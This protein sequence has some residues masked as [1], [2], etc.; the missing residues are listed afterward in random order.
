MAQITGMRRASILLKVDCNWAR[1][2]MMAARPSGVRSLGA[3]SGSAKVSSAMPAQKCLPVLLMTRARD[4]PLC[5]SVSS[6]RSSSCQN[7]GF[8]VLKASGRLSTRWAI[9]STRSRRKLLRPAVSKVSSEIWGM[10]AW[11]LATSAGPVAL[12]TADRR[13]GL[14][15]TRGASRS[16]LG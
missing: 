10:P 11:C 9:W 1:V 8:R 2:S 5:C 7:L 14:G 3:K 4:W 12:A 13:I 6:T 15:Q 16:L